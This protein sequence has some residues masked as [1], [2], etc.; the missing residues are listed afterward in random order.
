MSATKVRIKTDDRERDQHRV[1]RMP[2]YFRGAV[3]MGVRPFVDGRHV[4]SPSEDSLTL[5]TIIRFPPGAEK[6]GGFR[7]L[8][9]LGRDERDWVVNNAPAH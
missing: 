5:T 2:A 9:E 4:D 7:R 8:H 6:R 1:D 3:G